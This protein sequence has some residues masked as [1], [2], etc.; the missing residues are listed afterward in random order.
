MTTTYEIFQRE[1]TS[2]QFITENNIEYDI[3]LEDSSLNYQTTKGEKR[4]IHV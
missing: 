1:N 4:I 3:I 2:Y